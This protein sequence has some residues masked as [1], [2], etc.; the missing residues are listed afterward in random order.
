MD[1]QRAFMSIDALTDDIWLDACM[2][3][4]TIGWQESDRIRA[5]SE[6]KWESFIVFALFEWILPPEEFY[7]IYILEKSQSTLIPNPSSISPVYYYYL[8]SIGA[9]T[10]PNLAIFLHVPISHD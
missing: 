4:A 3:W 5:T 1:E 8:D 10:K 9:I 2:V 6:D 7:I